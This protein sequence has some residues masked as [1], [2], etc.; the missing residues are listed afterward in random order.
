[1]KRAV[2]NIVGDR[3]QALKICP[4]PASSAARA[5]VTVFAQLLKNIDFF[6]G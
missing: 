2:S 4:P 3:R 6:G 1:L 5:F